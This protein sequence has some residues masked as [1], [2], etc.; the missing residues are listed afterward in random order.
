[1]GGRLVTLE[2]RRGVEPTQARQHLWVDGKIPPW[3][4]L[5]VH[6]AD[7]D[8]TFIEVYACDR[9]TADDRKLLYSTKDGTNTPFHILSPSVPPG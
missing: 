6:A 1:L 7:G 4:N 8:F 5:T 2:Q 3:I 9:L